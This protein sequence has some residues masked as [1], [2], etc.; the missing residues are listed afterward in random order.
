MMM[1]GRQKDSEDVEV[2]DRVVLWR[3]VKEVTLL[4]PIIEIP[5]HQLKAM[6]FT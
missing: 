2:E 1:S 4:C 6:H 5:E 3:I